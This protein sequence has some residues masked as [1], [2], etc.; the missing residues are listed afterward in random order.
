MTGG[1]GHTRSLF[2]EQRFRE[3]GVVFS[4]AQLHQESDADDPGKQDREKGEEYE[5]VRELQQLF[6]Q[7]EVIQTVQEPRDHEG[8]DQIALLS[9]LHALADKIA[10]DQAVER[11]Q[12]GDAADEDL[13]DVAADGI[14]DGFEDVEA[15]GGDGQKG[16]DIHPGDHVDISLHIF[17]SGQSFHELFGKGKDEEGVQELTDDGGYVAVQCQFHQDVERH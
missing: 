2:G 16:G 3:Y 9:R 15:A 12:G 14:D 1:A 4:F 6:R 10:H 17:V 7:G 5:V 8:G 11:M 13:D